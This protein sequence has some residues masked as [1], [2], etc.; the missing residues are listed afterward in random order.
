M[1]NL[2]GW[3]PKL[4]DK[5]TIKRNVRDYPWMS[6]GDFLW[7]LWSVTLA[8][9]IVAGIV[10]GLIYGLICYWMDGVLFWHGMAGGIAGMLIMG[11]T[12]A[13]MNTRVYVKAYREVKEE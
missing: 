4:D 13:G 2:R 9:F 8:F 11:I 12:S 6:L 5:E 7:T 1:K 3:L 10:W